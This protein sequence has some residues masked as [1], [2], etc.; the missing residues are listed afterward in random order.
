M[1]VSGTY[2]PKN[3]ELT[4][5]LTPDQQAARVKAQQS[6]QNLI[7][8]LHST[9]DPNKAAKELYDIR[10]ASN[11]AAAEE[12]R[13][14]LSADFPTVANAE[15]QQA[16]DQETWE[17]S[18]G[19]QDS[20]VNQA[21]AH[22][23]E[24]NHQLDN[25]QKFR[26]QKIPGA[27]DELKQ[28]QQELADKMEAFIKKDTPHT[29]EEIKKF[30]EAKQKFNDEVIASKGKPAT[31]ATQ[32][33][34]QQLDDIQKF[35]EQKIPGASDELKQHQQEMADKMEAF[36]KLDAP[37]PDQIKKFQEDKQK[38]N[39][40]VVANA[41]G[42]PASPQQPNKQQQLDDIQKFREQQIPG[43]SNELK[44]HQQEL[45]DKMEAFINLDAPTPEQIKKFQEDKQK[46]NDEVVANAS[47]Q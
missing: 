7:V 18:K 16:K 9:N 19:P 22:L 31:P 34:Q 45:A 46:F 3:D 15:K 21:D 2:T 23:Q 37:T 44:Q 4:T 17:K 33:K 14:R 25:V 26:E 40:E 6:T 36:V 29:P 5:L 38:F 1:D 30:Q 41:Q 10:T 20:K 12:A 24:K 27:S 47:K 11:P 42:R 13:G 43:A 8:S 35:R 39:D 28:H 32:D